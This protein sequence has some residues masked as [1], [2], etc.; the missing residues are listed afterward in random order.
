MQNFIA[1]IFVYRK[2]PFIYNKYFHGCSLLNITISKYEYSVCL[3]AESMQ[4]KKVNTIQKQT[5]VKTPFWM[6]W[7][8][9]YMY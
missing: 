8:I 9:L 3:V 2:D 4:F 7:S 5:S 6:N 1:D